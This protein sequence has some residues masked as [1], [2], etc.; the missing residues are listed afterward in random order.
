MR[1]TLTGSPVA[2]RSSTELR[3][4][5]HGLVERCRATPASRRLRGF[6]L[7]E[8]LVAFV[9]LALVGTSLFR[10]FSGALTNVGAA[11]DYSRALLVAE[12]VLAETAATQPLQESARNGNSE[13]GAI[14]WTARVTPYVAPDATP[15]AQAAT[16]LMPTRLWRI[17]SEVTFTAPN[18]K[19]RTLALS[20]L[21]I[22]PRTVQ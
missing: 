2:S 9:V 17:T 1:W 4:I 21:R 18:G 6:S 19:P 22:A 11:G 3:P 8:V 13:D 12:S 15:D 10:L 16:D 20:T 14:A 7:L 5:E